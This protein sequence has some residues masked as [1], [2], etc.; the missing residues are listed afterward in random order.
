M[1]LLDI[2]RWHPTSDVYWAVYT[3]IQRSLYVTKNL[4]SINQTN[5]LG[6][7]LMNPSDYARKLNAILEDMIFDFIGRMIT[8]N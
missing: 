8:T 7:V 5:V 4:T 6:I 2:D 3:K 1:L